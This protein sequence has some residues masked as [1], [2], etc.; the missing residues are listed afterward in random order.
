MDGARNRPNELAVEGPL[1][2]QDAELCGPRIS[3]EYGEWGYAAEEMCRKVNCRW[4]CW[5]HVHGRD[6][7]I[8]GRWRFIVY[9]TDLIECSRQGC[10][11]CALLRH[12]CDPHHRD[13]LYPDTAHAACESYR[14]E[15][16]LHSNG[17]VDYIDVVCRGLK[18][19]KHR[20]LTLESLKLATV[21]LKSN[22][23]STLDENTLSVQSLPRHAIVPLHYTPGELQEDPRGKPFMD[24]IRRCMSECD[25]HHPTCSEEGTY[26]V[27]SRVLDLCQVDERG[28]VSLRE[29]HGMCGSYIALSY[30]WGS[31]HP[32][33]T[34]RH[35]VLQHSNGIALAS[36]PETFR[37]AVHVALSLGISL[38]WI[39]ALCIVQDD[40]EHRSREL[41]KMASIFQGASLVVIAAWPEDAHQGF[42]RRRSPEYIWS[43]PTEIRSKNGDRQMIVS[44]R[45]MPRHDAA[46]QDACEDAT[47]SKR[48]WTLQ[49]RILARRCLIFSS[50][51]CIWECRN[52]CTCECGG[53]ARRLVPQLLPLN[54][55]RR[56]SAWTHVTDIHHMWRSI[57][58]D[59]SARHLSVASD[60]LPAIS[61]IAQ[62]VSKAAQDRY[63][64]G[65]W[66]A[67]ILNQ[68]AWVPRPRSLYGSKPSPT[69]YTLQLSC[70]GPSWSWVSSNDPIRFW[71]CHSSGYQ[72]E[73]LEAHC[74]INDLNPFGHVRTAFICMKGLACSAYLKMSKGTLSPY[75]ITI[76][77]VQDYRWNPYSQPCHRAVQEVR[78]SAYPEVTNLEL[79]PHE[80]QTYQQSCAGQITLFWLDE[81][82]CLTLVQS[83]TNREAFERIGVLF[84]MDRFQAS[85]GKAPLATKSRI[86][87]CARETHIKLV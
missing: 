74:E 65:I 73:L 10:A 15:V 56:A 70:R 42:L 4:P 54:W 13:T 69:P 28:V 1:C 59:Y 33:K 48:A 86:P 53:G 17:V 11:Y 30:C 14:C 45:Q 6:R 34:E 87:S 58:E 68:L 38:L 62:Y 12:H 61:A 60:R 26:D 41:G 2:F 75:K 84:H 57:L 35:N 24:T 29:T 23:F 78:S 46:L 67:D 47:V 27:P 25:E 36:L 49:E 80:E 77:G 19:S 32:P 9:A 39:D 51:E 8:N 52:Q 79:M 5:H 72:A 21:P 44:R 63:L 40:D 16:M 20:E 3:I 71:G 85:F 22:T 76:E 82:S 43:K 81:L 31:R 37:D 64:A 83:P 7:G 18:C 50:D 55:S 66:K